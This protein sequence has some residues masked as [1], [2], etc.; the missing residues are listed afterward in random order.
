MH[1]GARGRRILDGGR[2]GSGPA[3]G[4]CSQCQELGEHELARGAGEF[5]DIGGGEALGGDRIQNCKT[6]VCQ[7][8]HTSA[9]FFCL[10]GRDES[11]YP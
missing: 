5:V 7:Q 1:G 2:D 11:A 3:L 8:G 6:A 9:S 10:Y 4:L